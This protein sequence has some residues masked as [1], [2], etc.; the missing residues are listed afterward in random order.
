MNK[1]T[2]ELLEKHF[3]T[4]F[5]APD[6]IKKL[7]E[8]ILTLAMQGKLVS[9]DPSEQPASDLL[10]EIEAEKQ[11]LVKEGQI[12]KPKPLPPVAEEEKPY[13]LP[14]GWEWA[15]L[16]EITD[17]IRGIT[18]PA[19]EK[20]KEPASGRIACLRTANV[21]K[22][23]EWSDLLYIDR[24]FMSKNSQLV[25]QDDIVMS[26]ANSRELVGKVAVVS[27]MP[28]NEATFGGFLGV[29]RT[30]KVAPLYVLHL[31]NTS[32]ARSSLIDAASQTT[33]IAN[34]SLGKLNPFL[35]P[36]PPISEQH[37]IVAKIDEL[38][39][40]CDELE[41][42]RTA[43]QG[44]RLTVHAAAIKQ[45]LN[46]AEPGQHQ[47]AQ[48]F[49]AE[50]FGELYTIKGN[51]AELRKAILQLAVM[52]KLV[53]QDPNDQPASE[54]LKE[55]EAEKQRLVQEGK[56]KKTKPLPPVTEEEK[57]YAL[58]QGWEWVRFGDLTTEISTGPFGSMIHKSDY[59]VD[60]VPLV[61]PSHMVDG[62]IFHDP[63]VTVSEI[64]AKKLD[65]HRLNTNDIVMA[66][67]G[68][69]GRCAIVTAESDGFLCG[70]GSF[71]LRF[72][73]RI[74]RQYI[75]TIFKTE[76]T[77]EFLG[78]NS[79]G[80]TMTNLNHGILN[81][82][83]VSLPPHPE[84]T[85]I[86]T[87]I[88][89]LMVMCDALDQQIEATSS[90]R[91]ELLNALIH[92]H[93]QA[94]EEPPPVVRPSATVNNLADYRAAIGCYTLGKLANAQYFG[95]TAAAKVLYLAQAHVGLKLNLQPEREAAGP[96]DK[97]IYDFERQGQGKH[98][99]EVN[100]KLLPNGRKKTEYRCLS[101]L[102]EP[103][104][105]AES[106]MSS[107]QKTEFDRLIYALAGK[108]TKEVEII[109]TLFAVWNDF[110]IDGTQPTDEQIITD[111]RENWHE[112]KGRFSPSDLKPWL[113]WLRKENFVPRGLSPRTTQQQRL[114]L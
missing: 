83:P 33:N 22:K 43:Q 25:R 63:S 86:V 3:D 6:G 9:Q 49:L 30:H 23:I 29:L 79:V 82:M 75:L 65:S 87:K 4:A 106:L 102:S 105:K 7:R 66:R 110:L 8:L 107:G 19:S 40:R 48:T 24:T 100:E 61:N 81:K 91:T 41:K 95:R 57:P 114:G 99:F 60:G 94:K 67:R 52:G 39:A 46:V 98:W 50:H 76:I 35:V 28:V 59:I 92:A 70:T 104:A 85:R 90:K 5:A 56:I 64:M 62:K 12:K 68:E 27:E 109:A 13:A 32:Y 97:W 37:R 101:A 54:L 55:I 2:A 34:I 73:D 80:T 88:D 96:L 42:L 71:V 74:Y 113:S 51:V 89:E 15:R 108:T 103:A 11:Q 44:A 17:I 31:L 93:S 77:R 18:F 47:R 111:M 58:P 72:V 78:G 36:V 69:M 1:H 10:Q 21:Q 45:L 14:Q 38:M 112:R 53:P 16:G 84:Q 20:T 26:M